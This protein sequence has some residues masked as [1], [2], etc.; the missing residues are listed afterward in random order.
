MFDAASLSIL[1]DNIDASSNL[2]EHL[3]EVFCGAIAINFSSPCILT[4]FLLVFIHFSLQI[5][6]LVLK[7]FF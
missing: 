5:H 7:P 3:A 2:Y 4:Y 6:T 1:Y